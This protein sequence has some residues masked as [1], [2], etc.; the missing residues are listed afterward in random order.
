MIL[1]FW[2]IGGNGINNSIIQI[3]LALWIATSGWCKATFKIFVVVMRILS[4]CCLFLCFPFFG[5]VTFAASLSMVALALAA[6]MVAETP[7]ESP[8]EATV[9]E[10]ALAMPLSS[11]IVPWVVAAWAAVPTTLS[12][13]IFLDDLFFFAMAEVAVGG[14]RMSAFDGTLCLFFDEF[15]SSIWWWNLHLACLQCLYLVEG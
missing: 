6:K 5:D 4:E 1:N 13:D 3:I 11:K 2:R 10:R 9:V 14:S 8:V 7:M 15:F 12:N